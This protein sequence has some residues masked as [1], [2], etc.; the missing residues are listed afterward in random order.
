MQI[1]KVGWDTGK[2]AKAPQKCQ[3]QKTHKLDYDHDLIVL[4]Q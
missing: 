1:Q 3:A 4:K 2:L